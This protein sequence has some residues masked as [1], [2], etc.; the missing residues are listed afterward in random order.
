MSWWRKQSGEDGPLWGLMHLLQP[1][2]C[3][4]LLLSWFNPETAGKPM[5]KR[6]WCREWE[7]QL[8]QC[9]SQ[10]FSKSLQFLSPQNILKSPRMLELKWTCTLIRPRGWGVMERISETIKSHSLLFQKKVQPESQ[11]WKWGSQHHMDIEG[12]SL[13]R[14]QVCPRVLFSID[15][16]G[17]WFST[18][19]AHVNL[20]NK[21]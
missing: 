3:H 13:T 16:S 10:G 18:L 7:G 12:E 21:L 14:I 1:W 17:Q 15:P 6:S 11:R 8:N 5:G 20:L 4:C 2:C 19:A 9:W